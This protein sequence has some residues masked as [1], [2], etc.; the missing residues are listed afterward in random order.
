MVVPVSSR[1]DV[2]LSWQL[3][4]G[5]MRRESLTVKTAEKEP[6]ERKVLAKRVLFHGGQNDDVLKDRIVSP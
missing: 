5:D 2:S 4:N 6:P 3:R 1:Y